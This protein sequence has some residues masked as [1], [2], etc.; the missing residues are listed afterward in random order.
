MTTRRLMVALIIAVVVSGFFTLW[1]GKRIAS[2]HTNGP[3][4]LSYM[5]TAHE[6]EAGQTLR[7]EDLKPIDWPSAIPLVGTFTKPQDVVGR[8]V[9]YPLASGEPILDKQLAA[10]G[11]GAG[12]SRKV[13]DG[14]RALSLKSDQVVG[15][16]G[17]LFPGTHV[18]VLVT[19]VVPASNSPIT[20]TVLQ[21]AEILA[22]G[23]KMEPD[24]KGQPAPVDVVTLLVSPEDAQRVVLASTQG[25]V[26][27]V[28]RNGRD[29]EQVK[30]Q[31]VQMSALG[32]V[33]D[34]R[35]P[36]KAKPVKKSSEAQAPAKYSVQVLNGDKSTMESF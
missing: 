31:P 26:H 33:A 21:N 7:A 25:R 35:S 23:L 32:Q 11:S 30:E 12:L 28:L 19:Y 34:A 10:P 16:A 18:D 36:V 8:T 1:F 17:F 24:P 27:F 15:V 9:L 13:P 5:A 22:A 29:N 14:M 6:V 2:T 20:S 4:R 3:A